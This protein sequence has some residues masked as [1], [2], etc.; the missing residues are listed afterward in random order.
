MA[1]AV[2]AIVG[3]H[4]NAA[5]RALCVLDGG[6][7][8]GLHAFRVALRRARVTVRAYAPGTTVVRPKDARRLRTLG[9]ATSA[10]RDADVLLSLLAR[11]RRCLPADDRAALRPLRRRLRRD[12]RAAD[13]AD[14]A[15][16]RA[17]FRSVRRKLQRR[18]GRGEAD[19]VVT[20]GAAL[21]AQLMDDGARL[22]DALAT[23]H[24]SGRPDAVHRARLIVK[25]LRYLLMPVAA[26]LADGPRLVDTLAA[27]QTALGD[28]HDLDVLHAALTAEAAPRGPAG[29]TLTGIAAHV[30]D[31]RRERLAA[32]RRAWLGARAA[33][34]AADLGRLGT[35][36]LAAARDGTERARPRGVTRP[37]PRRS[38]SG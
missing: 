14:P 25:R 24:G 4:L 33:A 12:R 31:Q 34:L 29:D 10:G 17:A 9:R 27:L 20:L 32:T 36:L 7:R 16:L 5:R 23:L 28:V 21:G 11:L 22:G 15:T 1:E 26:E 30:R 38:E 19:A 37:R 8:R 35:S 3:D 2:R 18:L 6:D 13:G